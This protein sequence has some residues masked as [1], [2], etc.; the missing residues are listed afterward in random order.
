MCGM[1]SIGGL[2]RDCAVA[3]ATLGCLCGG[4]VNGG[5]IVASDSDLID[6]GAATGYRYGFALA[7][8]G[9]VDGDGRDD[10]AVG[11][12][13]AITGSDKT[14]AV[15]VYKYSMG[16]V[17]QIGSTIYGDADGDRFGL[18]ISRLGHHGHDDLNGD[19]RA[20]FI[21]GAPPKNTAD[22]DGHAYVYAYRDVGGGTNVWWRMI[23]FTGEQGASDSY[24][25][26]QFGY[27]IAGPGDV[28]GDEVP[29]VAVA[30]VF[31]DLGTVGMMDH[32]ADVGKVYI[33]FLETETL[34]YPSTVNI[35]AGSAPMQIVGGAAG[36]E[37]G[38]SISGAGPFD[39][40]LEDHRAVAIGV[41]FADFDSMTD[42]GYVE[43]YDWDAVEDEPRLLWRI[44][45]AVDGAE[46]GWA[47]FCNG[48]LDGDGRVDDLVVGAPSEVLVANTA[49]NGR[50]YGFDLET[51]P[52]DPV[53]DPMTTA[54]RE[55]RVKGEAAGDQLGANVLD[56]GDVDGNGD[57]DFLIAAPFNDEAGL[58]GGRAYLF[59]DAPSGSNPAVHD[60]ADVI[61]TGQQQKGVFGGGIS[62][63]WGN[64][65]GDENDLHDLVIAADAWDCLECE[66]CGKMGNE[67][68]TSDDDRGRAYLF[69]ATC[70]GAWIACEAALPFNGDTNSNGILDEE[71]LNH[72]VDWFNRQKGSPSAD[73]NGDG[74]VDMNDL[75]KLLREIRVAN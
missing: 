13:N 62:Y 60:V 18:T 70:G 15:Y 53:G 3:M 64:I 11:A 72:W 47:S 71:D 2:G 31:H 5:E 55:W 43:I 20:D 46:F 37:L 39:E 61:F 24:G 67:E 27:Y 75:T 22:A 56:V 38:R 9:D 16:S 50:V 51:L 52:G 36:D 12:P 45:S 59:Y 8:V 35:G 34:L 29:D 54:D 28:N 23:K 58:Q 4:V 49:P 17:Q 6:E 32:E 44:E 25:S 26:D 65:D 68:C 69:L 21:I 42:A 74:Q 57:D 1:R 66:D 14:G 7:I 63:G 33:F 40:K 10:F 41:P 73:F 30:A 48:D 19:G